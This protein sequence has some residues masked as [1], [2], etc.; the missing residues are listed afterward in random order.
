MLSELWLISS[1]TPIPGFR[2]F[3][4]IVIITKAELPW[5][6]NYKRATLADPNKL[7][8]NKF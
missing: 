8:I 1:W 6:Q 2:T 3:A 7:L 5:L 4:M